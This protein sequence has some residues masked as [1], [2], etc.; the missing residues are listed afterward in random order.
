MPIDPVQLLT[1]FVAL[2]GPH[3]PALLGKVGDKVLDT[4]V[5][6]IPDGVKSAW[7]WVW[8]RVKDDAKVVPTVQ[9]AAVSPGNETVHG[10]LVAN[11]V[12]HLKDDQRALEE[13]QNL[14]GGPERVQEITVGDGSK[15]FNIVQEMSSPGSQK[16]TGGANTDLN[17]ITQRQ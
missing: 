17:G 2:V 10:L 9:L 6:A 4:A 11:L 3:I 16:I 13:L 5:D 14:L 15:L 7:N 8:S 1:A 12:E